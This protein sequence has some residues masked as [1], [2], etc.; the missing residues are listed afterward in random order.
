MYSKSYFSLKLRSLLRIP[1]MSQPNQN[2]KITFS[3]KNAMRFLHSIVNV[4]TEI[5]ITVPFV[6]T[7]SYP[8]D[9]KFNHCHVDVTSFTN[10]FQLYH[11]NFHKKD[12]YREIFLP[13]LFLF[14]LNFFNEIANFVYQISLGPQVQA[15]WLET[16]EDPCH[17]QS[18]DQA[19][20]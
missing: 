5:K 13:K 6:H 12:L 18:F 14:K 1:K 7:Y 10:R 17:S 9:V 19:R 11:C 3:V 2:V 16:Q 20:V 8:N 4:N 15:P